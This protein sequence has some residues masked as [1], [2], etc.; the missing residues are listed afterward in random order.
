[1]EGWVL[2]KYCVARP[3]CEARLFRYGMAEF[4]ITS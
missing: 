4:P 2:A 3:Y 1:M